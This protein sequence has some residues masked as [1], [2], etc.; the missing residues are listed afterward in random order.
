MLTNLENRE[1]MM[2]FKKAG[3]EKTYKWELGGEE[4]KTME[5]K[6]L[7]VGNIE[8]IVVRKDI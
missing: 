7:E 2:V 3:K 4:V 8:A 1:P 6:Y 5:W